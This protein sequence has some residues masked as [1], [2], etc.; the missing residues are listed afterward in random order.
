M[1]AQPLKLSRLTPTCFTF[2]LILGTP[3]IQTPGFTAL[4][5]P[6]FL[7]E[8]GCCMIGTGPIIISS[9]G[10]IIIPGPATGGP[11]RPVI[12]SPPAASRSGTHRRAPHGPRPTRKTRVGEMFFVLRERHRR[13]RPAREKFVTRRAIRRS[14]RRLTVRG[15]CPESRVDS[16]AR[17]RTVVSPARFP[18][19]LPVAFPAVTSVTSEHRPTRR[20]QWQILESVVRLAEALG[21][22]SVLR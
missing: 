19:E 17:C 16:A 4:S 13:F 1:M 14:Q 11:S 21:P 2:Q 20:H 7:W 8:S 22:V 6:A 9:R 5:E 10:T 18:A 12:A 15:R 3:F